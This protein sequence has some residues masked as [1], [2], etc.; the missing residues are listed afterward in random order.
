[1][2]FIVPVLLPAG[3]AQPGRG[4]P[5][6]PDMPLEQPRTAAP[7]QLHALGRPRQTRADAHL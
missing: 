7:D 5:T 6:V 4:L 1:M 3:P 2:L